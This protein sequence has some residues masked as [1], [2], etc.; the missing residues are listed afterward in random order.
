LGSSHHPE[1]R[2]HFFLPLPIRLTVTIGV[3]GSLLVTTI[4]AVSVAP[5]ADG[6]Y[7]TVIVSPGPPLVREKF[8]IPL[9]LNCAAPVP[10]GVATVP[11]RVELLCVFE[12][13][14]C[15]VFL[16][17]T[18][19]SP[20]SSLSG[21]TL[22]SPAGVGVAVG[23][24][25]VVPVGVGVA[26]L[27]AVAVGVAVLV[28]VGVGVAVLLDVAVEVAVGVTLDVEVEVAVAVG[29]AVLVAVA[30]AV[31]DAVGV[32]VAVAVTVAVAVGVGVAVIVGVADGVG[33]LNAAKGPSYSSR[34]EL[35]WSAT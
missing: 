16:A 24:G 23:V 4:I 7:V 6:V 13:L 11:V 20:N 21:F 19:R 2:P 35:P 32:A 14:K 27:V 28:A 9:T 26:V 5:G 12:I 18:L 30:V 29:V 22:I 17:P 10:V 15:L 1:A 25:L 33:S 31:D 3:F 34:R 8:V